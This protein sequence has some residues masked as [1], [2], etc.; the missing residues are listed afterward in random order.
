M[1]T[2]AIGVPARN[3]PRKRNKRITRACCPTTKKPRAACPT[4]HDSARQ[5]RSCTGILCMPSRIPADAH[6]VIDTAAI[7]RNDRAVREYGAH[8]H[9]RRHRHAADRHIRSQAARHDA[10]AHTTGNAGASQCIPSPWLR[11]SAPAIGRQA[12]KAT[13]MRLPLDLSPGSGY[14]SSVRGF[15]QGVCWSHPTAHEPTQ[16]FEPI[17]ETVTGARIVA[18][19]LCRYRG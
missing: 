15:M 8:N 4:L 10:R 18:R 1:A 5:V 16:R 12:G 14:S 7:S 11:L 2:Q 19:D 6:G 3:Y 9:A 13:L 17:D